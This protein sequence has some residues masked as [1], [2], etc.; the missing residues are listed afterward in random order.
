M[1]HSLFFRASS[2]PRGIVPLCHSVTSPEGEWKRLAPFRS[3]AGSLFTAG[4]SRAFQI[5]GFELCSNTLTLSHF[6]GPRGVV[7]LCHSVTSPEGEWKR[8]TPFR[9]LADTLFTVGAS[10]AV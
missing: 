9:S 1:N 5:R 8:Q 3:L 6:S 7:P 4:V 2:G 10:C